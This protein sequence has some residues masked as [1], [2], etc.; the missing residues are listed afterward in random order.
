MDTTTRKQ[1]GKK[2]ESRGFTLMELMLTLAIGAM[3]MGW[4]GPALYGLVQQ[5]RITAGCNHFMGLLESSRYQALALHLPL[6]ICASQDG[7]RCDRDRGKQILVFEDANA[8]GR[9]DGKE[10]VLIKEEL[11]G[12]SDFWLVWR[13]FRRTSYLRW[14]AEGRTDSLNGTFTL[15]NSQRK[16]KWLRQIVISRAGRIRVVLPARER[17]EVLLAAQERC[18]W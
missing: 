7:V 10:A 13:D 12:Q 4:A 16:D 11:W 14:A 1:T 9:L 15:C 8:N 2:Q 5:S 17:K 3:V 18:N 6:T